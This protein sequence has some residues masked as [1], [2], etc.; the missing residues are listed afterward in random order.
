MTSGSRENAPRGAW[1]GPGSVTKIKSRCRHSS[2]RALPPSLPCRLDAP[3]PE[4][5]LKI[6]ASSDA[7]SAVRS[8]CMD[9]TRVRVLAGGRNGLFGQDDLTCLPT[10]IGGAS[11]RSVDPRR[12]G[13]VRRCAP[14][15]SSMNS[16]IWLLGVHARRL[17]THLTL[18]GLSF[19]RRPS[20]WCWM[21]VIGRA[22]T[23]E[24][25]DHDVCV[26]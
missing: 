8:L 23:S 13:D 25:W 7:R 20:T 2:S 3:C 14:S 15:P 21:S 4:N 12:R 5:M 18:A 1:G 16:T 9:K 26:W 11:H 22:C 6:W 17:L 24:H 10:L 19:P